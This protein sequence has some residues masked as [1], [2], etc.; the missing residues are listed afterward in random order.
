MPRIAITGAAGFLGWH[1]ACRL[2]GERDHEAVRLGR[3]ALAD[4]AALI[5]GVQGADVVLH[6]AGM[7][8]GADQE[9]ERIN[10]QLAADLVQALDAARSTAH[11]VFAN[12]THIDRDT[13]YGAGKRAAA[14]T[15]RVWSNRRGARFTDLVLPNLFGE[16]ARPFYNSVVAT[17]CHQLAAGE[18]PTILQDAEIELLHAQDAVAAMMKAVT[19]GRTGQL[20][21]PGQ[22]IRV[23]DLLSTLTEMS[24][25]YAAQLIPSLASPFDLAL[26]NTLRAYR[27]PAHYPV[28]LTL[29]EDPRGSLF[30]AV[31]TT[32]GG[33]CFLSTTRPGIT[34]GNHYHRS[35]LERFLV[36]QGEAV[37]RI[38]RQFSDEVREFAVSGERPAYIDMPAFHTHNITNTGRGMLLTLFWSHEVFDPARPDTYSEVVQ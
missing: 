12:S 31:R 7:N 28:A 19:Q 8:R 20:R 29:H 33:Q 11:V 36:V 10:A 35:K 1:A 3:A 15:L 9:V 6:L 2:H 24:R 5:Q 32:H 27:Y 38:R 26:F 34:R 18:L 14:E 22:R 16:C 25:Q 37:I 4:P 30:E 13:R 21:V 23:S 17:F